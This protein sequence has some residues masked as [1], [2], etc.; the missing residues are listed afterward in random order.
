[1][2]LLLIIP[3]ELLGT[4]IL[5]WLGP[6]TFL[7]ALALLLPLW[8]GTGNAIGIAYGLWLLQYIPYK[9]LG[10]WMVSPDWS[11]MIYAYQQ[12]WQSPLLL[13]ALSVLLFGT[14]LW[15]ANRTTFK[16]TQRMS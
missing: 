14:A 5:G 12:F 8:I 2:A 6:M 16:L 13:L 4:L 1:L 9:S 3:P 7:S 11:S 10:T 15:F